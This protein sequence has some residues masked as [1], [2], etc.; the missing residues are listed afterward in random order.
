MET[1][2]SPFIASQLTDIAGLRLSGVFPKGK[3]PSIRTVRD[4]KAIARTDRIS[5]QSSPPSVAG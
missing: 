4:C 2:A 1:P 5:P 3:E